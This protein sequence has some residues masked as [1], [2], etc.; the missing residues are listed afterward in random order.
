MWLRSST[1]GNKKTA[2]PAGKR[3]STRSTKAG[4]RGGAGKKTAPATG[5][6][7]GK[8]ISSRQRKAN[9][10][11][12]K[13]TSIAKKHAIRKST[14]KQAGQLFISLAESK[15]CDIVQVRLCRDDNNEL[16]PCFV[17]TNAGDV[18]E[19][20]ET[21]NPTLRLDN[22]GRHKGSGP[23]SSEAKLN[24][25]LL[26]HGF[27]ELSS[28]S[29]IHWEEKPP[30]DFE[31][32]KLVS[33]PLLSMEYY[34]EKTGTFNEERVAEITTA[35]RRKL[36]NLKNHPNP[37]KEKAKL[38]NGNKP[39]VGNERAV[40]SWTDSKKNRH[41]ITLKSGLTKKGKRSPQS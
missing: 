15:E 9:A 32:E 13:K 28:K 16:R 19:G 29:L 11:N 5:R 4:N 26:V 22:Y 3:R 10:E 27:W 18:I 31:W 24:A 35:T 36:K 33:H 1:T 40:I 6:K 37:F 8:V 21:A 23:P 14:K 25:L 20:I 17:V 30:R 7:S 38:L 34:D 41:T 12:F 39:K 2:P